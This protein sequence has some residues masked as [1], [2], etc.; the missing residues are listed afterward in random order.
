MESSNRTKATNRNVHLNL[1]KNFLTLRVK[2]HWN[3][4]LESLWKDCRVSFFAAIKN[5]P[6]FPVLSCVTYCRKLDLA[7][8]LA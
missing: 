5:L 6:G 1:R 3:N 4:A 2:E 7:E 8:K